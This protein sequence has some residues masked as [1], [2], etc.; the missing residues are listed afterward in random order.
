MS[1]DSPETTVDSIDVSSQATPAP[2][3]P[4]R[5]V[6]P[7]GWFKN[8]PRYVSWVAGVLAAISLLSSISLQFR[9]LTEVPRD[10]VDNYLI[11]APDT[12][13][14]WAF[15]LALLAF[16]L[17][18][19]KRIAWW[20]TVAYVAVYAIGNALYLFEPLSSENGVNTVVRI[21]ICIGV[22]LHVFALMYLIA[23]Y[24]QFYT[25]LLYTSPSP[26]DA[27]LSRMPSSA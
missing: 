1:V 18:S 19:R 22:V 5:L 3:R 25:C 7:A 20:I 23:S 16:A 13:F 27:T 15:V 9:R 14:A 21:N 11:S 8:A 2:R 24:R 26:R 6:P 17:A 10:Y 12:S 4:A